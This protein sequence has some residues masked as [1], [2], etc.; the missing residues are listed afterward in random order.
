MV[1]AFERR[2]GSHIDSAGRGRGP[3]TAVG[4]RK[5]LDCMVYRAPNL[6]TR[7]IRDSCKSESDHD[8]ESRRA[9][10]AREVRS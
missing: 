8:G 6:A 3:P 7:P 2:Q 1:Q 9:H 5:G 10:P 4:T